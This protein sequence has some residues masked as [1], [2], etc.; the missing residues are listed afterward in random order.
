MRTQRDYCNMLDELL[1][2]EHGLTDW[3]IKFLDSLNDEW[4]GKMTTKQA[5][6]LEKIWDRVLG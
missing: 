1:A 2:V 3:E 6:K 4:R 5:E